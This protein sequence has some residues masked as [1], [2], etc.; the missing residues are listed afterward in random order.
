MIIGKISVK[1]F[2]VGD[3]FKEITYD[4]NYYTSSIYD[5]NES[6]VVPRVGEYLKSNRYSKHNEFQV[7]AVVY[8][9]PYLTHDFRI[10][11]YVKEIYIDT[12]LRKLIP[13]KEEVKES[14]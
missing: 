12:E 13:T 8:E 7:L 6:F 3:N 10:N 9:A 2:D 14:L 4:F 1:I 5:T 11:I